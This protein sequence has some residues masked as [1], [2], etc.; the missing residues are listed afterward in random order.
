MLVIRKI[1]A[2]KY[3]TAY[4]LKK[5]TKPHTLARTHKQVIPAA[6]SFRNHHHKEDRKEVI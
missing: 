2:I 3:D 5:Q 1:T 6:K 4:Y